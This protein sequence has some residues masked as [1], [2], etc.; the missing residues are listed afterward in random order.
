MEVNAEANRGIDITKESFLA[1]AVGG[2]VTD[3]KFF[4]GQRCLR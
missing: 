3:R 2:E 4:L 1:M